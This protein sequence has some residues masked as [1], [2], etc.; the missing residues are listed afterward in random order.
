MMCELSWSWKTWCLVYLDFTFRPRPTS[1]FG[2]KWVS[3][4]SCDPGTCPIT[5]VEILSK[6]NSLFLPRVPGFTSNQVG[7]KV[8]E[9]HFQVLTKFTTRLEFNTFLS[10]QHGYEINVDNTVVWK[11][12]K[13]RQSPGTC[14]KARNDV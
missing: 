3:S 4:L 2:P 7:A 11:L 10:Q 12:K 14:L 5:T 6:L 8:F 9:T 13:M 1:K